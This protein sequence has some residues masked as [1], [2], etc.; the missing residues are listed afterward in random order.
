MKVFLSWS[1]ERSHRVAECVNSWLKH[2]IQAIK[3]W[4]SSDDI[5]KGSIWFNEINNILAGTSSG[6]IFLTQE[7]KNNPW[8]LFESGA[9]AKS[10]AGSKTYVYTF[11]IDLKPTDI[12][13]PLSHF[14][15]TTSNK[16]DMRKL[17][18]T[19][20]NSLGENKLSN[21]M[22]EHAFET[23]W[24][25][26][27]KQFAKIISETEHI[28][29]VKNQPRKDSDVLTEILTIV[30][31]IEKSGFSPQYPFMNLASIG[32]TPYDLSKPIINNDLLATLNYT[33]LQNFLDSNKLHDGILKVDN[34]TSE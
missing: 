4:L 10:I 9:L 24:P 25:Q 31:R 32:S 13:D 30:R 8:I 14:N 27:E 23:N 1:G 5:E 26:F 2:V 29:P 21:D 3:P 22:L 16:K 20:N 19:I 15:H 28:I 12:K 17:L 6:I 7:N 34:A 18:N 33:A 11:L